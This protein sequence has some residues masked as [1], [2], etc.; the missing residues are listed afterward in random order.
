MIVA[1]DGP[2]GAGKSTTAVAVARELGFR[3]LDSGA[4]YRAVALASLEDPSRTAT[5]HAKNLDL[6]LGDRVLLGGRDVTDAIRTP[7]VSE[8]ASEVA[9]IPAVRAALVDLQRTFATRGDWV[10][11]GRDIGTVVAPGAEIKVF[12]TASESERAAR[13]AREQGTDPGRVLDAQRDRDRRDT[14]RAHSPLEPA[15]DAVVL[16]STALSLDEVVARVV[17]LARDHQHR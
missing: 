16:D 14:S 4:M 3:R 11:E 17:A 5:E 7:E 8:R 13:R 9:A 1:I 12:L 6:E 2:A 15:P 10:I